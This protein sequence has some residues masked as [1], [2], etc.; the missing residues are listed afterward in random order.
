MPI[1]WADGPDAQIG[2]GNYDIQGTACHE[3]GH[4][5]GLNHTTVVGAT[6]VAAAIGTAVG[7]RSIEDDDIQGMRSIYG[8]ASA[9]KITISAASMTGGIVTITGSFFSATGNQVWFTPSAVTATSAVPAIVVPNVASTGGGTQ[10]QVVVPQGSGPGDVLVKS[11]GVGNDSLSNAWPIDPG[12]P[13]VCT[14]PTG[15]CV[16]AQNSTGGGALM[17][18]SGSTSCLTNDLHLVTF[19]APA[20]KICLFLFGQDTSIMVPFGNG[21]RC[22]N[23]P[24]YRLPVTR[25]NS[26]GDADWPL[27]VN[28]LPSGPIV[29]GQTWGFQL[30]YRDPAAGGANF[31]SSDGLAVT[32][33]P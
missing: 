8:V 13:P 20:D 25:T 17:S 31:N 14:T 15:F 30:W 16:A 12:T 6:M 1:H 26:F 27:D 24:L 19:G 22:L 29:S 28:N 3:Y 10:I 2:I 32:F 21:T 11:A 18:W 9:T 23:T 7:Q 33:C 4:A 5:L